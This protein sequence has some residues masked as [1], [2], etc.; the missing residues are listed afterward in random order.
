MKSS[1]HSRT[2]RPVWQFRKNVWHDGSSTLKTLSPSEENH[3]RGVAVQESRLEFNRTSV[4]RYG[5][6]SSEAKAC[7]IKGLEAVIKKACAARNIS[8]APCVSDLSYILK[9]I[10]SG[11]RRAMRVS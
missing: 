7:D 4:G 6:G 9:G 11:D 3:Q 5:K 2:G 10:L 8:D 1:L